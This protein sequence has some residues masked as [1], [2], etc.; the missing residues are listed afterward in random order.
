MHEVN[1]VKSTQPS[2]MIAYSGFGSSLWYM[3][4]LASRCSFYY[5]CNAL[6]TSVKWLYSRLF[7]QSL[8][9]KMKIK[10]GGVLNFSFF[11]INHFV[12]AC[13]AME[14]GYV[15]K[16]TVAYSQWGM[17]KCFRF[18]AFVNN[19]WSPVVFT[20][21]KYTVVIYLFEVNNGNTRTIVKCVR[22]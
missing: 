10:D 7:N 3:N 8:F 1:D 13:M 18:F 4:Q 20:P 6:L 16:S 2:T 12:Y 15:P 19:G 14:G 17:V 22:S 5:A 21:S 11:A 9:F